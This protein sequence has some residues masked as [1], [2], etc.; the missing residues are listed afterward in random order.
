MTEA[1]LADAAGIS[2]QLMQKYEQAKLRVSDSRLEQIAAALGVAPS[3]FADVSRPTIPPAPQ[4]PK[5][6]A[7]PKLRKRKSPSVQK[8][9]PYLHDAIRTENVP[10][11]SAPSSL[12]QKPADE[13]KSQVKATLPTDAYVGM[14]IRARRMELKKSQE[15]LGN[16]VKL[17]FQQ[18]QKYEKGANRVG[19]SR[20]VEIAAAL[21][22]N[23]AYF[24]EGLPISDS[25][26]V[27][28]LGAELLT[29]KEGQEIARL[30]PFI[31]A[32]NGVA[33]VM[34]VMRFAAR[35]HQLD[36]PPNQ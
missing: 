3:Y 11:H 26:Q 8:R 1:K 18:I 17:T 10:L 15:Q 6:A 7:Q 16:E 24:F 5:S 12:P 14:R 34:E 32:T 30:W 19:A 25:P 20:L 31:K 35:M 13:H 36:L 22:V 28:D 4:A 27:P 21:G 2:Q 9:K 33:M 29:C 23:P